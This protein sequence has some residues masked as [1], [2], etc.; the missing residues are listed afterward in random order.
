[1]VMERIE[2]NR[3]GIVSTELRSTPEFVRAHQLVAL[4][5]SRDDRVRPTVVCQYADVDGRFIVNDPYLGGFGG[6]CAIHGLSLPK[7]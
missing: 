3:Y 4:Q 1:M 2:H 5:E 7:T 6:G